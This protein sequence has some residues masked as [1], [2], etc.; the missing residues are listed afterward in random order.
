MVTAAHPYPK[1]KKIDQV[2]D[3]HGTEVADPYR[4]LEDLDSPETRAWIE[5]Q[6]ALTLS[7]LEQIPLRG[8]LRKRLGDLWDYEKFSLPVKRGPRYFYLYNS[9]LQ[10]QFALYSME[11][12]D[13]EPR[14]LLDPNTWSE[15]GTVALTGA[16]I[17]DDGA[18]MAY[19][20]ST[21][22]SDWQEWKFMD[23]E[24][25][26]EL[27]DHLRWVKFSG[28]SWTK[29]GKGLYYSRY[30]EPEGDEVKLQAVNYFQ[31]LFY[32][33][34]GTDQSEDLLVYERPDQKEWGFQGHVTDDG[35]YLV[36]VVWVGTEP[37]NGIFY[38][39]LSDP[40]SPVVELL[41]EFDAEYSFIDNDGPVFW[42]MTDLE[43]PRR[44]V[45]GLD[46]TQPHPQPKQ[47][48]I[49]EEENTLQAIDVIG[50]R[51]V[52]T[53]L[54]DARSSVKI[55]T[56]DG[57]FDRDVELPG[58][59]TAVGFTGKRTDVETF[60]IFTS[61]TVPSAI[62]RYDM[63]TNETTLVRESKVDFDPE[64][65]E[66]KQIFY[67][68]KDG[69]RVPMFITHRRGLPLNGDNP[70]FLYGYG[71]FRDSLTPAFAVSN[72][73]WME[74]GGVHAVANI[75][76]GGE[77]GEE[78]HLAGSKLNRQ[79]VFDDF[80]A[81][82]E[83]LIENRYTTS[84][85][86]A[87]GG[88]SN[89]GLLVGACITQRP[90]LFGAAYIAVGVLDML[91]F[92]KFTIGWGW[93][94]DYGSPDDPEEFKAL[95]SYSPL[96]NLEPAKQF[97]ATIITTGDHDDRVW[98]GHSFKFAA[99]LQEAQGG[100]APALIRVETRGGHGMGKPTWMVIEE[101]A[102]ARAFLA[103]HLGIEAPEAPRSS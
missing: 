77:Y 65:Y 78:W 81:A 51:F 18:L 49:P 76:G 56:L 11:S 88:G 57:S 63:I 101:L 83:W 42:I 96:H 99:A 9:G 87:I 20:V 4:W 28:A 55:F 86:L 100:P 25:E 73:A 52:G 61:F 43:A 19:G 68:S 98:P 79:N 97:P 31:K 29:D 74:L 8:P 5:E 6:N 23:I 95:F 85:R 37:K 89:G 34:L 35:R 94:S 64:D 32:H 21:A 2:D 80:I 69:T 39:D 1:T 75:R 36:I 54:K 71:G 62:Y 58:I 70:T 44:R 90:E 45:I 72:L 27:S 10:N 46:V 82:A 60:Y 59:G 41:A 30:D 22:G 102:D 50:D 91:R 38:K 48:V 15:D 16:A 92:H 103:F 40:K 53:Y 24:K 3:Y 66:T 7:H 12:L 84:A 67:P 26:R 93:V 17:T 13:D 47:E 33:R 14:L